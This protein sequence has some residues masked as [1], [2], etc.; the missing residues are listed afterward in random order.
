MHCD[1]AEAEHEHERLVIR[2]RHALVTLGLD[3]AASAGVVASRL[4]PIA[5]QVNDDSLCRLVQRQLSPRRR[6]E[7]LEDDDDRDAD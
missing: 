1:D 7:A 3:S 4:P 5:Y 2:T 6:H